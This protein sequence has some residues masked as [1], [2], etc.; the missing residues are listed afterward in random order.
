MDV[1]RFPRW[2]VY[3]YVDENRDN[4]IRAWLD[5]QGVS[6]ALRSTLQVYFDIAEY[7]GLEVLPGC[8]VDVGNSL[9]A[10]KAKREGEA[11]V[12]LTFKRGI[13]VEQEITLL[14]GARNPKDS[15]QEAL[16]NLS[17]LERDRTRRIYEP[18]TRAAPRKLP[19]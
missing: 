9:E 15:I 10:F 8:V 3:S 18:I 7:A 5:R 12:F 17:E 1:I 6:L 2:P 14:A 16:A 13:F 11:P 4:V 19:R